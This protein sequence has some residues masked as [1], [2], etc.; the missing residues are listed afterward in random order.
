MMRRI[1]NGCSLRRFLL[2]FVLLLIFSVQ[3]IQAQI[4]S[5][6]TP[7]SFTLALSPASIPT[8]TLAIR[9]N[10]VLRAQAKASEDQAIAAGSAIPYQVA[11]VVDVHFDLKNSGKWET[12]PDGSRLWRLRIHSPGAE[13]IHLIYDDWRIPKYAE[14]FVYNDHHT[15]VFGA[16]Y[17]PADSLQTTGVTPIVAGDAVIVEYHVGT[18]APEQGAI[19]ISRV[20][21][22][23]RSMPD[24]GRN[25]LDAYGTSQPCNVNVNCPTGVPWSAQRNAVM[26]IFSPS[27]GSCSGALINNTRQDGNPYILTAA[28]CYPT[29]SGS[30]FLFQFKFQS[31]GCTNA[32]AADTLWIGTAYVQSRWTDSDFLLLYMANPPPMTCSPYFAGWD[33]TGNVPGGAISIHHPRADIKKISMK[34]SALFSTDWNGNF[35]GTHWG[36]NAWDTGVAEPGSSGSPWYNPAGLIVGQLHGGIDSMCNIDG[37]SKAGKFS[38][39]WFG[40]GNSGNRLS[41]YLDPGVGNSGTLGGFQ[42][43]QPANDLPCNATAV[44]ALPYY[45][46]GNTRFAVSNIANCQGASAPDVWWKLSVPCST[47]VTVTTCGSY[48]DTELYAYRGNCNGYFEEIGCNDDDPNLY[49][50]INPVPGASRLQF[51]AWSQPETYYIQL[52]GYGGQSGVYYLNITGV[53]TVGN[54]VC[55]GYIVTDLPYVCTGSTT[56]AVNQYTAVCAPE[57]GSP[58]VEFRLIPTCNTWIDVSTCGSTFDTQFDIYELP[59]PG[60]CGSAG[61]LLGCNDDG[62]DCLLNPNASFLHTYVYAN[63]IYDINLQGYSGASG[64]YRLSITPSVAGDNC[65]NALNIAALPYS[66]AWDTR[67][68]SN[69]FTGCVETGSGDMIYTY[70]PTNC[71]VCRAKLCGSGFDTSIRVLTGGACP[72]TTE[73]ACNDDYCGLQ[74]QLDFNARVGFTYY[75]IVAGFQSNEGPYTLDVSSIGYFIEPRDVCSGGVNI[76]AVPFSTY[77]STVCAGH[78]YQHC[79]ATASND[80]VYTLSMPA[81]YDMTASLCGSSFDTQLDLRTGTTCAGATL[82]LCNDDSYCGNVYTLQSNISWQA[83]AGVEY[84]LMIYGYG[85]ATGAFMLNVTGTPCVVAPDPVANFVVQVNAAAGE[86]V[87]NWDA[88]VQADVYHIYASPTAE[89]LFTPAHLYADVTGTSY[90]CPECFNLGPRYFF[91]AIAENYPVAAAVAPRDISGLT[92]TDAVQGPVDFTHGDPNPIVNEERAA[93][94]KAQA[95]RSHD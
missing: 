5:G 16:Y 74:S 90:T 81:C 41:D 6:G 12:L 58:D 35:P 39:S 79:G 43:V 91:G 36:L 64:Y 82:L 85:G 8:V 37:V 31:P 55:P 29:G 94:D 17:T 3:F 76:S 45:A 10:A 33:R 54:D 56:C 72:G 1:L 52:S 89:D 78:E 51:W 73:V 53:S 75:I 14:L 61:T 15:Q 70:T 66:H 57:N 69:D 11:D 34:N 50:Q 84:Y 27:G 65:S 22:H 46:N 32:P 95:I 93:P 21:H 47:N 87:F 30:G 7:L 67:C 9:D 44:T 59:Y 20:L 2:V 86:V 40:G 4:S 13:A 24:A 25:P 23:F 63:H 83:Q 60:N 71:H 49:C 77:G 88:A 38:S 62:G 19:S 26:L 80:V 92:K 42:P 48:F 18:A 68:A 28:H